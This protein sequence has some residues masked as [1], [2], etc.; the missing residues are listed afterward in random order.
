MKALEALGDRAEDDEE[1][2][3]ER[4][5]PPLGDEDDDV[6]PRRWGAEQDG[7]PAPAS[8]QDQWERLSAQERHDRQTVGDRRRRRARDGISAP[9]M[10][11]KRQAPA[12]DGVGET[13]PRSV[14][15]LEGRGGERDH[16]GDSAS[17]A[18]DSAGFNADEL[19]QH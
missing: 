2:D 15:T 6:P 17:H 1:D 18:G 10:A 7:E 13:R 16:R 9:P 19:F 4:F 5:G 12:R 14:A 8:R 11:L 3:A